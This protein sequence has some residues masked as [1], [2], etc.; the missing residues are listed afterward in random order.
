[1][2]EE[3]KRFDA[4]DKAFK[5]IMTSTYQNP[6]AVDACTAEGL[7]ESLETLSLRLDQTQKR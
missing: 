2:P 6:V 5:A 3:A 1:L 4:A 7:L